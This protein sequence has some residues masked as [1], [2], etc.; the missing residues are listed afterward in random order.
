MFEYALSPPQLSVF[1]YLLKMK[2]NQTGLAWPSIAT[3]ARDC[4]IGT[5][6][7]RLVVKALCGKGLIA[8]TA[9]Y[10][11]SKSGKRRRSSNLYTI[12]AYDSTT[13]SDEGYNVCDS[14]PHQITE[15]GTSA[16]VGEINRTIPNRTT[17]NELSSS[18]CENEDD[19]DVE[20]SDDEKFRFDL[21]NCY[22]H[23][24][25][26][27]DYPSQDIKRLARQALEHLWNTDKI[28][29]DGICYE[30]ARIRDFLLNEMSPDELDY[31]IK[32]YINAEKVNRP[33]PYLCTCILYAVVNMDAIVSRE[34]EKYFAS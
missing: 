19:E 17:L 13:E 34:V 8:K 20:S 32:Q 22:F 30:N 27:K 26:D 31:A 1:C 29:V 6:T 4:R 9:Q 7:A 10:T 5:T 15:G 23:P 12:L 33:L 14:T 25:R 11:E 21:D 18:N 16:D 24:D 28:T 3:I 2:G